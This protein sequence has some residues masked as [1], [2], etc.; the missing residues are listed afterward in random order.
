MVLYQSHISSGPDDPMGLQSGYCDIHAIRGLR[1]AAA[2][3]VRRCSVNVYW[4]VYISRTVLVGYFGR[5]TSRRAACRPVRDANTTEK[6]CVT[7]VC[8]SV[9]EA[10]LGGLFVRFIARKMLIIV[11]L[12]G[13]LFLACAAHKIVSTKGGA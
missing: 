7:S 5:V 4:E 11:A 9:T 6:M 10:S 8:A 1:Y 3:H 13:P 2:L 12:H